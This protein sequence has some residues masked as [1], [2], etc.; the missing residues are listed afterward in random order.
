[1]KPLLLGS[2]TFAIS[3]PALFAVYAPIPIQEQGQAF[4]GSITTGVY[5]DSNIFGSQNNR[6][7]SVVGEVRP[8]FDYN[9]S[10]SDQTFFSA[11]YDLQV[12]VF[13][14]RP[15]SDDVMA[16][17][18][19]HGRIDHAFAPNIFASISDRFAYVQNPESAVIAGA[20]L[21]TDQ[22]YF[23]NHAEIEALWEIT[24]IWSWSG[25]YRTAPGL[26]RR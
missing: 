23:F 10:F 7:S 5:Y 21:Q 11:D 20:P 22:S 4:S 15:G 9:H 2:L 24:Q 17:N 18:R 16:N 1:M 25:R 12:L 19:L 6:I 3:A 26:Y 14:N 13:E 8:H